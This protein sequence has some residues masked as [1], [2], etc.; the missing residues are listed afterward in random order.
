MYFG[1]WNA[2]IAYL[3]DGFSF[4]QY[5]IL[6]NKIS[7]FRKVGYHFIWLDYRIV[8]GKLLLTYNAFVIVKLWG[9]FCYRIFFLEKNIQTSVEIEWI[10]SNMHLSQIITYLIKYIIFAFVIVNWV[11]SDSLLWL[12]FQLCIYFIL[13][14][15]T[16]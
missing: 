12:G 4:F 15:I 16:F 10:W 7:L 13:L 3:F 11:F 5:P 2:D 14:L 6:F 8:I 9:R 1:A